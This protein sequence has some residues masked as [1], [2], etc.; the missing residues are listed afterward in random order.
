MMNYKCIVTLHNG[1]HKIVRMTKDV[2]AKIC[3][4]Y[5]QMQRS[6]FNDAVIVAV[7]D[8]VLVLNK[9]RSLRFIYEDTHREYL[10]LC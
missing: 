10:T 2:V 3:Y 9:C 4:L 1:A 5:R 7:N 6:I 8:T